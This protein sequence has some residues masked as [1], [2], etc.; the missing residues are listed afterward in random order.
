MNL[1]GSLFN[2]AQQNAAYCHFLFGKKLNLATFRQAE[3]HTTDLAFGGQLKLCH[4]S[5]STKR[6]QILHFF[7][8]AAI[9]PLLL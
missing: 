9:P 1:Y 8:C 2:C 7:S 3:P 6:S 5:H 4:P